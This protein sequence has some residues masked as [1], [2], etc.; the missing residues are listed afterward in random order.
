VNRVTR[1]RLL[2]HGAAAGALLLVL[3]VAIA[4]FLAMQVTFRNP[5]PSAAVPAQ[6]CAPAPCA[7]FQGYT[8]WISNLKVD[9]DLVSMQVNFNLLLPNRHQAFIAARYLS[10]TSGRLVIK[11]VTL[12]SRMNRSISFFSSTVQ[13]QTGNRLLLQ[14][15]RRRSR[16]AC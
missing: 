1:R 3:L 5:I 10:A 4:A 2:G 13:T 6:N 14:Y 15:R 9:G 8:L 12:G 16:A 7:E 11:A